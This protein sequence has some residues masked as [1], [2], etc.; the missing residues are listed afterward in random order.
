M[1]DRPPLRASGAEV[2]SEAVQ[3]GAKLKLFAIAASLQSVYQCAVLNG[4]TQSQQPG[5]S[6]PS[7]VGPIPILQQCMHTGA[8]ILTEVRHPVHSAACCHAWVVV[9]CTPPGDSEK[10]GGT[11]VFLLV[12][13]TCC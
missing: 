1:A 13:L 3:A 7:R 5:S 10:M 2:A 12:L 4:P 11:L 9:G 6:R 8:M